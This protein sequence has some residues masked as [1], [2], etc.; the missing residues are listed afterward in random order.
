[1]LPDAEFGTKRVLSALLNEDF[2]TINFTNSRSLQKPV[3]VD[4]LL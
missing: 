3:T 1:M 4:F 2:K